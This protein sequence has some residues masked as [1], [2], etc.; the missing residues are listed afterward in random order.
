MVVEE[1]HMGGTN[2]KTRFG[3]KGY[4]V[5]GKVSTENRRLLPR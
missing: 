5:I 1:G 3:V 2:G 4:G